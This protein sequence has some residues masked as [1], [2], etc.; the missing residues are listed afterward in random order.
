MRLGSKP[1]AQ[2]SATRNIRFHALLMFGLSELQWNPPLENR[3][4]FY[5]RKTKQA[6]QKTNV[7]VPIDWNCN[8]DKMT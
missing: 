5:F 2:I 6:D 8:R 7:L 4:E 1:I 3:L